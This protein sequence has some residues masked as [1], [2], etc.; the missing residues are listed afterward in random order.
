MKKIY[1]VITHTLDP[2][3]GSKGREKKSESS[4]V[5]YII[6]EWSTQSISIF[7]TEISYADRG[8]TDMKHIKRKLV[9]RPVSSPLCGLRAWAGIKI[10]LFQNMVIIHVK[11]WRMTNAAP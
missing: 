8:T 11:L 2:P 4:H 6:K 3:I 7:C 9:Q 10:Q 1:Y 5:A